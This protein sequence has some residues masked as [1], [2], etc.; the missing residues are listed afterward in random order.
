[1]MC[2]GAEMEVAYWQSDEKFKLQVQG[3]MLSE[4]TTVRNDRE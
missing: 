2:V 1:M 3:E 4:K